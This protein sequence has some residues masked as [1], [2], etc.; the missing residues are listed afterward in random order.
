M[1]SNL[2]K[3]RSHSKCSLV[4]NGLSSGGRHDD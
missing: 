1:A 3:D 4:D 2:G